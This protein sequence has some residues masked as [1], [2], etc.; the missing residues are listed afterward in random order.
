M[1]ESRFRYVIS[2]VS[3]VLHVLAARRC[4]AMRFLGIVDPLVDVLYRGNSFAA[5]DD[6]ARPELTI[7]SVDA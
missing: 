2:D 1:A 3:T 4:A 5:K 7:S 6:T